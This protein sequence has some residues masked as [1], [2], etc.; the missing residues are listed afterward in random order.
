MDLTTTYLGL[1]LKSP[2]IVGAA[3]PLTEDLDNLKRIE[4]AGAAAVVLH[5]LFEEQIRGERLE[6]HHHSQFGTDSFAESLTYFPE[7][8]IFHV[9]TQEYLNH[10]RQAKEQTDLPII[11]SINGSSLGGWIDYARQI[12]EAGADALELNIY[13]VPTDVAT[14]AATIEAGYLEVVRAV[15]SHVTI[16]LAVKLS[17]YF[18]SLGHVATELVA[19][20]ANGLVL[21]NRFYQPD[22][23]IEDL[24]VQPLVLLSTPQDLRLPMRWIA[25]LYGRVTADLIATSGVHKA[26]DVL[27]LLMAGAQ[28]TQL[29]S[30]LLRHGIGHLATIEA[31]LIQWLEDHEYESV[32]QLQ[33]SMSQL[34]CP[35]PS[36]FER[37]QYMKAVQTY[38]PAWSKLTATA[39]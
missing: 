13:A 8:E 38:K 11:A 17:P 7:P 36:E 31:D 24:S 29:V 10:I 1:P 27:R 4:D 34:H 2:L 39:P 15:R 30:V 19:A 32:K 12:Q 37:A 35:N 18:T 26:T 21:F 20:G 28:A 25:I 3:A 33:G 5:S 6:L 23:N 16:P 9:G 14:P 22:I